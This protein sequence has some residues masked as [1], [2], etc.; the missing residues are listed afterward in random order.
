MNR[1]RIVVG[2]GLMMLLIF[3]G[4]TSLQKSEFMRKANENV[5][6]AQEALVRPHSPILGR[7]TR[8]L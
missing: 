2:A 6:I 7:V 5:R 1:K 4:L 8:P 3:G